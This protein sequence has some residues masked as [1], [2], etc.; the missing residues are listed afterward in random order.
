[1]NFSIVIPLYNESENISLL[2]EEIIETIKT[3]K[4]ENKYNFEILY[5]DDGSTDNTF[6]ILKSL[7]T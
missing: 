7:K 3:L 6:E 5:V 4:K 2:N 1:M